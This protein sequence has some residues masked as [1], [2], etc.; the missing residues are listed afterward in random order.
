MDGGWYDPDDVSWD[1]DEGHNPAVAAAL[2]R[3]Y[4]QLAK[5]GGTA[6]Y[7]EAFNFIA[8]ILD[9][10]MSRR[11]RLATLFVAALALA[12]DDP[13]SAAVEVIDEA[14]DLALELGVERAQESLL[15]LRASVNR[16]ILQVPDA[17]EDLR[18]CLDVIKAQSELREL[19][20]T[21]LDT[22]LEAYLRLAQSEFLIGHYDDTERLL[23]WAAALIPRVPANVKAP[24]LLAWTRALVFRWRGAYELALTQAMEAADGYAKHG[25]PGM[26]SRIQGIVGEIALD[27]AERCQHNEQPLACAGFLA[28]AEPYIE[29]AIEIAAASDYGSSETMAFI[30]HARLGLLRGEEQDRTEFLEE[31]AHRAAEHQDVAVMGQAYTQLGRECEGRG[32]ITAARHWY[33]HALAILQESQMTALG[34]WAQRA[35]WRLGGEMQVD[36]EISAGGHREV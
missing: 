3:A 16:F 34:V 27:L 31:L 18:L 9:A 32:D 1:S 8:G 29:R 21:E 26:I 6:A 15:F 30:T 35:L 24:S 2:R 13:P 23:N 4:Q 22:Q 25:H 14:L 12:C 36:A 20:P 17:V 28:L 5:G 7:L 19:T 11:Q 10:E 33:R